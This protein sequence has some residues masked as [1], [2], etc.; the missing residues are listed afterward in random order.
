MQKTTIVV[1]KSE[2]EVFGTGL[3]SLRAAKGLSVEQLS[4]KSSIA[5]DRLKK[6]EACM[7]EPDP[8]E[9]FRLGV[10]LQ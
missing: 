1:V 7:V 6:I 4:S 5:L 9:L 2:R 10:A 3:R 8:A